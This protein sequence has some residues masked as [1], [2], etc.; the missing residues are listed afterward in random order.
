MLAMK[1]A[2][3]VLV[4]AG[5]GDSGGESGG[6]TGG[7]TAITTSEET[8]AT[9]S[10]G[11]EATASDETGAACEEDP[12]EPND[13][14][15]D[16]IWQPEISDCDEDAGM[17]EGILDWDGDVDW[18]A[19]RGGDVAGC[20]VDPSRDV[21]SS[22]VLRVCKFVECVDGSN[23]TAG[24]CP[25]GTVAAATESGLPGCCAE[26]MGVTGFA[27]PVECESGDDSAYIRVRID[28]SPIDACVGYTID[29]HY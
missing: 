16:A 19:Y 18:Y 12:N 20:I 6:D 7:A 4:L 29:Y 28:R 15:D 21:V 9:D 8:A 1:R 14:E 26:G 11:G 25:S 3:L 13:S 5:C 27:V 24:P 10:S 23:A 22:H 17:I 2:I